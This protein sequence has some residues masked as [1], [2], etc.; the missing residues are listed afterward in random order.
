MLATLLTV[1]KVLWALGAALWVALVPIHATIAAIIALPTGDLLLAL[2][3][4][5]K[6]KRPI[7]SAG[8]KRTVAKVV[9]YLT[10]AV[11]A[12]VVE[13]WLTGPA[14]P[15]I[16]IVTGL[17]G[18][19]ELKSC[20]EHIDELSGGDLFKSAIASLAPPHPPSGDSPD[21]KG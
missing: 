2:V 1:K 6:A 14:V 10:A 20:L 13:T 8:I 19:T 9:L 11:L 7:T 17:I 12:F 16:K 15:A 21:A 3:S 5:Y 4:A 18:V